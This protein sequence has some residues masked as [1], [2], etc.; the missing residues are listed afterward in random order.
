VFVVTPGLDGQLV[1]GEWVAE[2]LKLPLPVAE[3]QEAV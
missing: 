2:E 3:L 1:R